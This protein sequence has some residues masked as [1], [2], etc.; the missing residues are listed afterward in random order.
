MIRVQALTTKKI[1][2]V[3]SGQTVAPITG[4]ILD[5]FETVVTS[6]SLVD[7]GNGHYS[8][9]VTM[10]STPGIYVMETK[11]TLNGFDVF[12]DRKRFKVVLNEVD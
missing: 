10:P 7:E 3:S 4:A 9:L 1:L 11:A 2:W 6:V 5:S 12:I 8:E